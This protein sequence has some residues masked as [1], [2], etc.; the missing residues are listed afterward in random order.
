MEDWEPKDKRLQV[1]WDAQNKIFKRWGEIFDV[2]GIAS[3]PLTSGTII[4]VIGLTALVENG[5]FSYLLESTT[6]HE[7]N[8]LNQWIAA[9]RRIGCTK[10]ADII[11]DV[12]AN[13]R[14][15]TV[16]RSPEGRYKKYLSMPQEWRVS[17]DRQFWDTLDEID[18]RLSIYIPGHQD[19]INEELALPK[20]W[21]PMNSDT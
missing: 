3:V 16:T 20:G 12:L 2:N 6:N 4:A 5:G 17:L 7:D 13:L 14:T 9:F 18:E 15:F 10:S 21:E 8:E 1:F 11:V 19:L